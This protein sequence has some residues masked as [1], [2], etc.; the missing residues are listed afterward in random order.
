VSPSPPKVAPEPAPA[1]SRS[2]EAPLAGGRSLHAAS[3]RQARSQQLDTLLRD[4]GPRR[5]RRGGLPSEPPEGLASGVPEIDRLLGRGF[6]RGR[7][8]EICG[9]ASSGRTSLALTLLARTTR[10]GRICAVVDVADGFDPRAAEAAGVALDRV[11]WARAPGLRPAL[12]AAERLL[13]A[14]GFALVLLDCSAPGLEAP[15]ATWK[16]LARSAS[17]SNAAL[18]L[19]SLTRAAGTAAEIALEMRALRARFTGT[20]PLLEGLEAE[21]RVLRCRSGPTGERAWLRLGTGQE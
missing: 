21:A 11:L 5:L 1:V 7:L 8:S 4:L 3:L 2:P 20:P 12:R 17:G 14:G 6:P 19:L 9:A 16:R 18:V 13:E 15:D 10:A